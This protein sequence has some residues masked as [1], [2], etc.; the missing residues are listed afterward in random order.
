MVGKGEKDKG[1]G[2]R[3]IRLDELLPYSPKLAQL[4]EAESLRHWAMDMMEKHF[5][6]VGLDYEVDSFSR[7]GKE[8]HLLYVFPSGEVRCHC[9][10]F[11]VRK[12]C[13]HAVVARLALGLVKVVE[14]RNG[15]WKAG[16]TVVLNYLYWLD[17]IEDNPM[18]SREI[19]NLI[20]MDKMMKV[21]SLRSRLTEL[22]RYLYTP[23]VGHKGRKPWLYYIT[24]DGIKYVQENK[25][26]RVDP[27]G[28]L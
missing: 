21:Q 19:L 15:P 24:V 23:L 1:N 6:Q 16:H 10:G 3:Q 14:L 11:K 8:K 12:D 18:T 9:K 13:R 25:K 2:L 26:G 4:Q 7:P 22:E 28:D 27:I 20:L 17:I 5:R